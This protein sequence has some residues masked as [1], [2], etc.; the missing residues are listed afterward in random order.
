MALHLLQ[1][2]QSG[3]RSGGGGFSRQRLAA[4]IDGHE[5]VDLTG[6]SAEASADALKKAVA[7]GAIERLVVAGGDGL[8]HLAIQRVAQTGIAMTIVPSG[9]G[10]DF[11][12]GLQR[13][14]N[15]V[16]AD[17]IKTVDLLRVTTAD[18]SSHRWVASIVI[19]GFP[20]AI[21]A[22]A[23]SLSLPL[24]PSLYTVAAIAELPRFTR[25]QI[26][27]EITGGDESTRRVTDT[28]MLAIGNTCF[29]GGG[30]L[31]CP[32]ALVDDGLL[33]FTSIE[34][35]GRLGILQ[36]IQRQKGGTADWDE[37]QRHTGTSI[38]LESPGIELW[39]DGERIGL[40]PA[41]VEVVPGALAIATR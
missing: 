2:P 6:D 35:V 20:A 28:A 16:P 3:R 25:A 10:N 34:D 40:T 32:D 30:M 41:T 38:H 23:N 29:F 31:A 36:H 21:N 24:G 15:P 17:G 14:T 33:H 19:A 13:A 27:Y 9:T 8:V 11:A 4:T 7:A 18:D 37:V 5:V 1:N 26:A 22:R 12:M 39:G